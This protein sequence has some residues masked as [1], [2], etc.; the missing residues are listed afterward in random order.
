MYIYVIDTIDDF[1]SIIIWYKIYMS[2]EEVVQ[3][4]L[5]TSDDIEEEV[6]VKRSW[7]KRTFSPI[8]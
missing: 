8:G 7:A 6:P 3:E 2:K 5:I 4:S 1:Y